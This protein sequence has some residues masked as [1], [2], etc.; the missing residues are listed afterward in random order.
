M[1][2]AIILTAVLPALCI[3]SCFSDMFSMRISNQ[4]CLAILGLFGVFVLVSG[5]PLMDAGWHLLA[6]LIVLV[7]SFGLFAAGWI[8]G[9]DAKLVAV[10]A[11]W[12]GFGQLWEYLAISSA[13]GGALTI[14]LLLVRSRPLP[15]FALRQSWM[16]R[17]HDK[18]AGVPYGM[19]LGAT[20]LFVLPHSSVWRFAL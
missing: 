17:L 16:F 19:A 13:L 14:A 8:G 6:G 18:K 2:S 4:V 15:A 10:I 9:G 20:A 3:Y 11:V 1:L 7:V 5:M 12:T